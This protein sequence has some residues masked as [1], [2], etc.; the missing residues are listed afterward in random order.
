MDFGVKFVSSIPVLKAGAQRRPAAPCP[1]ESLSALA[2]GSGVVLVK[3]KSY[4]LEIC[5]PAAGLDSFCSE[6]H[7]IPSVT[8][9]TGWGVGGVS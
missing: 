3:H 1:A 2:G 5:P 9:L 4:K 6:L 7:L 8:V